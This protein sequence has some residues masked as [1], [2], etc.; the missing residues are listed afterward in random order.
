MG[1]GTLKEKSA[2]SRK[3][4]ETQTVTPERNIKIDNTPANYDT[5]TDTEQ[6]AQSKG[7]ELGTYSTDTSNYTNAMQTPSTP[8]EPAF[9]WTGWLEDRKKEAKQEK[10]DAAKMQQYHALSNVLSSIGKL[11]GAAVGGAIGGNALDSAPKTAEYKQSQGYI[12][13]FEK[14]KR[15]NDRLRALEN[16]EFQLAYGRQ[17]AA[18]NRAWQENQNKIQ[19]DYREKMAKAEQEWRSAENQLN[20]EWNQAVAEKNAEKQ[21]EIQQR[22]ITLRHNYDMAIA[23]AKGEYDL[24]VAQ[25]KGQG[26]GIPIRFNNGKGLY[27]SK[28]DY[29]GMK[30]HFINKTVNGEP[31]DEVNFEQFLS[32]NP[33]LVNDY[34]KSFGK[35][36]INENV[37][38]FPFHMSQI[39]E[40]EMVPS[41][42]KKE[43]KAEPKKEYSVESDQWASY[44]E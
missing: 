36:F 7:A 5:A 42:K 27:V 14:A 30:R 44:L 39:P 18:E 31:I 20:R 43:T 21:A 28:V 23:K 34:M 35:G 19:M 4:R 26:E 10:T 13:A 25:A 37:T 11:G 38:P 32:N 16:Q 6:L 40:S 24:A 22:L 33:N 41:K 12:D 17:Q 15:A 2:K 9:S 1:T 3:K 29:D 8:E